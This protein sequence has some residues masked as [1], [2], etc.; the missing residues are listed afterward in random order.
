MIL[1]LAVA[2]VA[3]SPMAPAD[4]EGCRRCDHRGVV[5]C[6]EH[7]DEMLEAEKHVLFCSVA[8][9]CETCL[10][11]LVI[12]CKH[13]DGGPES[14]R[15]EE[16]RAE[17]RAWLAGSEVERHF[18]RP[19]M[20][21]ETKHFE[22]VFDLQEKVR[23]GRKKVDPHV[24]MHRVADDTSHVAEKVVEH[25]GV[26]EDDIFAKMRMWMWEEPSD[27]ASALETFLQSSA[28]GDFKLLGRDPVFSVWK[29]PGLFATVS[30][31]RSV[32]THNAGHMLVSNL[33]RERDIGVIGGGWFDAGV[34]HWYEY[35]RFEESVNYCIEEASIAS[36]F[37][38]GVWKAA[39]R[40]LVDSTDERLVPPLL[41]VPTTSM[42]AKEQ[43]VCWSFYDWL[44]VEKRDALRP[45]LRDLKQ[46]R[47][48]REIFT[49]HLGMGVLAAEDAWREW[50]LETY[51]KREKRRRR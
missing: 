10:G 21:C 46:E 44:V 4:E 24:L 30:A 18:E 9:R 26:G 20:R 35:D 14:A 38:N 49:E 17:I 16:R 32:F 11:A 48:T 15:I 41:D 29:E 34:G 22:L 39:M 19:V 50:V 31:V 8:A 37:A 25:F 51:P 12:D 36:N 2:L 40:K 6:P 1:P 7:D 43:A 45:M 27:H 47:E 13:C 28:T 3:A 23:E 5:A 33:F 42:S